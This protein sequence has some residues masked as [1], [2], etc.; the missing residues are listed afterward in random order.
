MNHRWFEQ[1]LNTVPRT[2][3]VFTQCCL[4]CSLNTVQLKAPTKVITHIERFF[5]DEPSALEPSDIEPL[6]CQKT[7]RGKWLQDFWLFS[8]FCF[9]PVPDSA[10][11]DWIV[12]SQFIA[13]PHSSL[14]WLRTVAVGS[15]VWNPHALKF[16]PRTAHNGAVQVLLPNHKERKTRLFELVMG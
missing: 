2:E 14:A 1:N 15:A 9:S 7:M 5:A 11:C 6:S 4:V 3:I 8:L 16:E 10:N 12:W 13:S